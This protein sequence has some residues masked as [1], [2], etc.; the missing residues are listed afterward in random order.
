MR[1]SWQQVLEGLAQW[2][3]ALAQPR[4]CAAVLGL[5]AAVGAAL[6]AE[7]RRRLVRAQGRLV[8]GMPATPVGM[9][10][11][12][13]TPTL[14]PQLSQSGSRCARPRT[15]LQGG[16]AQL[17]RGC[18]STDCALWALAALPPGSAPWCP[19]TGARGCSGTG[20]GACAARRGAA[21][22]T[23]DCAAAPEWQELVAVIPPAAGAAPEQGA[24]GARPFGAADLDALLPHVDLFSLNACA[25]RTGGRPRRPETCCG[26]A[27]V[28]A[29]APWE[30]E[31]ARPGR[32][33]SSGM[34]MLSRSCASSGVLH[35]AGLARRGACMAPCIGNI[36]RFVSQMCLPP[37]TR[38]G[39]QRALG[40]AGTTRLRAR[41]GSEGMRPCH[42]WRRTWRRCCH[43]P[44]GKAL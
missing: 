44:T 33:P 43:Q 24:A 31:E 23:A 21:C 4:A 26:V 42:G 35:V 39:A 32:A 7:G 25:H 13:A 15:G 9:G 18:A 2:A 8:S 37:G 6:H 11:L 22:N 14:P 5:F 38:P 40:G 3:G 10:L 16:E 34:I 19:A 12:A 17:G 41:A 20:S 30:A 29:A 27:G 28:R 36:G 1:V